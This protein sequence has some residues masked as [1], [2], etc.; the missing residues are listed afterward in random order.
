MFV[1]LYSLSDTLSSP[2]P[3]LVHSVSLSV[4]A[5]AFGDKPWPA[6]VTCDELI[7]SCKLYL[8]TC[9]HFVWT[10]VFLVFFS[11]VEELLQNIED[12]TSSTSSS[13]TPSIHD[14]SMRD[15]FNVSLGVPVHCRASPGAASHMR[16]LYNSARILHNSACTPCQTG[17]IMMS[18]VCFFVWWHEDSW[19]AGLSFIQ[20]LALQGSAA[21]V[22]LWCLAE[23]KLC[24]HK[25]LVLPDPAQW[26]T[27]PSKKTTGLCVLL[28]HVL[29]ILEQIE[30][31]EDKGNLLASHSKSDETLQVPPHIT[32]REKHTQW[33]S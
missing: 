12:D 11:A 8:C 29:E 18:P 33:C 17:M 25:V 23:K 22:V 14:T 26:C 15:H 19:H 31:K 13:T 1:C 2:T 6:C 7:M 32:M 5:S 24:C 4:H 9:I 10:G 20:G 27:Q 3:V 16:T 28:T 30:V 21:W